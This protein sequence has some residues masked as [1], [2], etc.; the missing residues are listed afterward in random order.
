[1]TQ[2]QAI[3]LVK[4]SLNES[5]LLILVSVVKS[6]LNE[7]SVYIHHKQTIKIHINTYIKH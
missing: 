1:M 3:K 2:Q 7:N 6:D 5:A 4:W